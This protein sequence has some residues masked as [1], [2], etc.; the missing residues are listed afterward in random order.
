MTEPTAIHDVLKDEA[1]AIGVLDSGEIF[2]LNQED[3]KGNMYLLGRSG[4]GKSVLLESIVI[5]DLVNLRGGLLIDSF[6]DLVDDVLPYADKKNVIVFEVS[7]GDAEFN[8]NKFKK[9]VDL[10]EIKKNK[11][12][13]CKTSY[14]MIGSHVAREVGMYILDEFYKLKKQ[15]SGASLFIDEFSNFIDDGLSIAANKEYGIKCCLDDQSTSH[16]SVEGLQQLFNVV[17]HIICFNVDSRTAR[18]V[19]EHFGLD[20]ENL[21]NVEKFNFYAKLKI[22]NKMTGNLKAKGVFPMPY[23]KKA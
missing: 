6:G 5:A 11:F 2:G 9:E 16:Y 19:A 18:Q 17:D 7:K 20:A 23:P 12:I 14:P 15:L 1:T 22:D 10:S 21:K 3:R 4:M 8:I 13:L